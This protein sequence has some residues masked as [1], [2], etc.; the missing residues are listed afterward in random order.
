VVTY[1]PP[2]R[3]ATGERSDGQEDFGGQAAQDALKDVAN[4][5]AKSTSVDSTNFGFVSLG[6]GLADAAG[7]SARFSA[8]ALDFVT[9]LID[10][11]GPTNRCY[12]TQSPFFVE[13]DEGWYINADGPGVSATRCDFDMYKRTEKFPAGTS[14]DGKGLDGTPNSYICHQNAFPIRQGGKPCDNDQWWAPREPKT[15]LK[16]LEIYYLRLQLLHDHEQ[17][18]RYAAR[19][20]L[21]WV[22]QAE[23]LG[24]QINNVNENNNLKGYSEDE[25]EKA[26][27]YLSYKGVGNGFGTDVYDTD[28]NF[29]KLSKEQL[30]TVVL[31]SF[32]KKMQ[33]RTLDR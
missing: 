29:D 26:G 14:S 23:T 17:P 11:E 1:N 3:G 8:T 2:G 12:I 4:T 19:E 18:T 5:V 25:L 15:Y 21:R 24:Y 10:V 27:A 13:E 9:W 30:L 20:A 32:V 6:N 33:E 22:T 16:D 28:G 7:A 31:P